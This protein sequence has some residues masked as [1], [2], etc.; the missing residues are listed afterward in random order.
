MTP[1]L[2]PCVALVSG[3]STLEA[4]DPILR[5]AGVRLVRIDALESR[6]VEPASWLGRL[7]RTA[8]PDTVVV[9]SQAAVVNGVQPWLRTLTDSTETVEF[10]AAG[11]ETAK[12]LRAAGVRRVRQSGTLGA[13][14]ILQALPG[15]SHRA[16]LYF[17]S[18]K[19][20]PLLARQLRDL[21]HRVSD[22][23]VYRIGTARPFG[24]RDRR[25]LA[26]ADLVVATSPSSLSS[27]RRGLHPAS[28]LRL[29]RNAKLV[30]LGERSRRAARGH[31]FRRIHVAPSP[32]AQRFT[33]YLLRELRDART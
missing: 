24:L 10:W 9:T 33:R 13:S 18:N 16:I 14:G 28:F 2:A 31:G 7:A 32:N 21:G 11:P 29:R 17:R 26:D 20:G 1:R 30:V 22:V 3:P 25:F 12:A 4:I 5:N 6:P 19:A 23:V 15:A 8:M 27:L